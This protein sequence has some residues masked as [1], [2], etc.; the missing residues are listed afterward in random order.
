MDL[1]SPVSTF[2]SSLCESEKYRE[3]E[4]E[5]TTERFIDCFH[6]EMPSRRLHQRDRGRQR[7]RQTETETDR[8]T[9][10]QTETV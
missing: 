5:E 3:I 7:E 10:G 4:R 8:Q 2:K 6:N 1:P 9:D